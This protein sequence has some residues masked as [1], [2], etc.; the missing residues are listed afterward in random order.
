MARPIKLVQK[1]ILEVVYNKHM[2][3]VP[4]SLLI[5]KYDLKISRPSLS[6]L[7]EYCRIRDATSNKDE[8]QAINN[9]LY[10]DWILSE[11]ECVATA[12]G[13]KYIGHMPY[14]YWVSK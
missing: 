10:P 6:N 2:D 8:Q 12:K 9:S 7:V 14:G 5:R 13:V 3:G 11:V 4:L 1:H